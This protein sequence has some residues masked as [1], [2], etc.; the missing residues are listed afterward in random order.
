MKRTRK[1]GWRKLCVLLLGFACA[2]SWSAAQ[3]RSMR[4]KAEVAKMTEKKKTV[5]VGRYL[6]DVPADA[7]VGLGHQ[8]LGGFSI[9]T[10]EESE[11]AFRERLAQ[12]EIEIQAEADAKGH[13]EEGMEHARDLGVPGMSGRTWVYGRSRGYLMEGDRRVAMESVSVEA[14]AHAGGLSF[15]LSADST[16][17]SS[18]QAAEA[19]LARLQLRGDDEVPAVPGF[20]VQRAVFAEPLPSHKT[21]HI[22]MFLDLPAHPDLGMVL[23]S[24][25]GGRSG[26]DL[27][28][29]AARTDAAA[30]MIESFLVTK[31]RAGKRN[32]NGLDSEENLERVRELNFA[33]TYAFMWEVEGVE[34]DPLQPFLSFELQAGLNRR[35]GGKPVNASLHQDALLALWDSISSSIRLREG[36]QTL[37]GSGL[38]SSAA[39]LTG[40]K[41]SASYL[42]HSVAEYQGTFGPEA[43]LKSP[44]QFDVKP[45][46]K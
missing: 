43:T 39:P 44:R 20:C 12:R 16:D 29:R 2:A 35:T 4:G 14:H 3:V 42:S 33:R 15:A 23:A 25:P 36:G 37:T 22:V 30:G 13:S 9:D 7:I 26:P 32:L 18:V 38:P 34:G 46:Q 17:E 19:L 21:E 10:I 45:V 41:Y 1:F 5:C 40:E 27:L 11:A 28:A 24:L 6:I 8:R 31:L